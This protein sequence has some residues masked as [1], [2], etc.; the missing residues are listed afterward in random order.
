[1]NNVPLKGILVGSAISITLGFISYL[2]VAFISIYALDLQKGGATLEALAAVNDLMHSNVAYFLSFPVTFIFLSIAGYHAAKRSVAT[3][4]FSA[5]A[6]ALITIV[7]LNYGDFYT[8]TMYRNYIPIVAG[9]LVGCYLWV[10]EQKL[11]QAL[12]QGS[13]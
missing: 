6:V 9:A 7:V 8:I 11:N 3:P 13:A 10:R 12:K 2:V 1:M 4:Y 5:T